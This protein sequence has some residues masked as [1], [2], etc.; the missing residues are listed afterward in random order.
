M[1]LAFASHS[2]GTVAF[3]FFNIDIDMLLLEHWF[4]F[5]E[6]F[7]RATV[8]LAT[9][10][11][12]GAVTSSLPGYRIDALIDRGNVN[13]AIRRW[14]LSGFIGATYVEFPFPG[15]PAAFKQQPE[16]SRNRA[17][18]AQRVVDF[19]SDARLVMGWNEARTQV[20]IGDIVFSTAGAAELIAYVDRGG[21]PRWRDE[22]RP[23]YVTAMGA[24]LERVASPLKV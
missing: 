4:F 7:C 11:D 6:D 3:G 17:W 13:A 8:E 24:A 5:A 15:D 1:P 16:G 20:T 10:A 23:A 14:D 21:Y 12:S 9:A 2:H 19:G 18:A 22:E